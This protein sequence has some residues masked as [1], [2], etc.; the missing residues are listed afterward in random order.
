[1]ANSNVIKT[2][3]EFMARAF[4]RESVPVDEDI[5]ASGF[6]N[7]LFAMQLVDFVER[8]FGVEVDADDL[9]IDNFRTVARVAALVE[10]KT[11]RAA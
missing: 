2:I 5:F 1:M 11:A 7:S 10:R 3:G 6:T 4:E 8:Q 9:Q